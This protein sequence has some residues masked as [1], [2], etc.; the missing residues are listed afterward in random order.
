M[1]EIQCPMSSTDYSD[2]IGRLGIGTKL[3]RFGYENTILHY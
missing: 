3:D 1:Q 2:R